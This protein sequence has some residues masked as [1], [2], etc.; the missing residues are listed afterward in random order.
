[1]DILFYFFEEI[2][3]R[4]IFFGEDYRINHGWIFAY[5]PDIKELLDTY[6]F[7]IIYEAV[8]GFIVATIFTVVIS[9]FTK[10]PDNAAEDLESLKKSA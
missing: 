5:L 6:F 8:P 9:L 3:R 1:M 7:G 4:K 2:S 10:K